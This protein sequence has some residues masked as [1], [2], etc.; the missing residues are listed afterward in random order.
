[1]RKPFKPTSA[2]LILLQDDL[3]IE[4]LFAPV[5]IEFFCSILGALKEILRNINLAFL[6]DAVLI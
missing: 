5:Q 4:E 1:M 6:Q 3:R 2:N